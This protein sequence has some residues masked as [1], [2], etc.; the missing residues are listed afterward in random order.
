M[1]GRRTIAMT[2]AVSGQRVTYSKNTFTVVSWVITEDPEGKEWIEP[3]AL[4]CGGFRPMTQ[5]VKTSHKDW[6]SIHFSE[7]PS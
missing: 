1:A 5:H 7:M 6:A 2:S 3:V 4:C